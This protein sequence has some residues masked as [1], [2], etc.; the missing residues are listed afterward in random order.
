LRRGREL[1]EKA[2]KQKR[3][4]ALVGKPTEPALRSYE[5]PVRSLESAPAA[6]ASTAPASAKYVPKFRLKRS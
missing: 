5:P 3:E 4:A 1:E 2:D 6:A